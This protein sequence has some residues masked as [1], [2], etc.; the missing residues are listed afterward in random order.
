MNYKKLSVLLKVVIGLVGLAGLAMVGGW[1]VFSY[2]SPFYIDLSNSASFDYELASWIRIIVEWVCSVPCFFILISA[3]LISNDMGKGKLLSMKNAKRINVAGMLLG[4]DAVAFAIF[5]IIS[6]CLFP[7][8]LEFIY[9]ILCVFALAI[10]ILFIA[11]GKLMQDTTAIKKEN[12]EF[13]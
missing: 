2:G 8:C 1:Y 13:I 12:E 3:F 9:I 10:S 5:N 4:V 6:W 11:L 7:C